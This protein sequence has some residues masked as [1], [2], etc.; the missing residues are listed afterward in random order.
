MERKGKTNRGNP[1]EGKWK[2]FFREIKNITK[3]EQGGLSVARIRMQESLVT[4]PQ[5][6]D[7][8]LAKY[9]SEIYKGE[10]SMHIDSTPLVKVFFSVKEIEK[11]IEET[12]FNK[13]LRPD[14]FNDQVLE[15]NSQ[16]HKKIP[17]QL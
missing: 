1:K 2:E 10:E 12:N 3:I 17:L 4:L 14:G 16:L 5:A 7:K 15:A 6:V 13:S 9:F 11:A 8:V